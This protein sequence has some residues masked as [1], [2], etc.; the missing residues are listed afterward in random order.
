MTNV[1]ASGRARPGPQ[2]F[3]KQLSKL[4]DLDKTG[5]DELGVELAVDP[6]GRFEAVISRALISQPGTVPGTDRC[7]YVLRPDV[8]PPDAGADQPGPSN[9]TWSGDPEEAVRLLGRYLKKRAEIFELPEGDLEWMPAPLEA[10]E[11]DALEQALGF[12][13]PGDLRALYA[14][15]DG[16]GGD[17]GA[18]LMDRHLWFDLERLVARYHSDPWWVAGSSWRNHHLH[19]VRHDAIP[20]GIVRRSTRRP[21]WIPFAETTGGDFLAVDLDPAEGGR[22]GQVIR[23]GRNYDDGPVYVADSMTTLL[24]LQL[25]ALERGEYECDV[26]NGELW[27]KTASLPDR[28]P[29]ALRH[30]SVQEA[31]ASLDDV[32]ELVATGE[33]DLEP[34]RAARR[35]LRVR[36]SDAASVGLAALCGVPLESLELDLGSV[37]LAP[38]AEHP[39]LRTVTVKTAAPLSLA[40]L[41]SC[42]QLYG[43]DLSHASVR[44]IEVLAEMKGLLYLSLRYEQWLELWECTDS[45]PSLVVP[46]LAGTTTPGKL[47]EWA[48]RFG[49]GS[50]SHDVQYYSGQLMA[51]E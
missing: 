41:R 9:A 22:P 16:D 4:Y 27:I 49:D 17:D 28:R 40:P 32:Q 44:D 21:G 18:R 3:R 38:L 33:T 24:R 8:L 23:V 48:A 7:L 10:A 6:T 12:G 19:A 45:L 31:A 1:L 14:V 47:A 20:Y 30:S 13:L 39:T 42:P 35:L 50:E 36:L 46:V 37:D 15:A 43:L 26:E 51:S 34:L 5:A 11:I 2:D 25:E 29:S